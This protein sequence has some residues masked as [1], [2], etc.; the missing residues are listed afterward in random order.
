VAKPT[1]A[2][3][4]AVFVALSHEARRQVL[5]LLAQR[6]GHLPSG[7]LAARFSHSWPTTTR[8]LNV[9]AEAGLVEVHREGRTSV[10]RLRRERLTA[11]IGWWLGHFKPVTAE[12]TWPPTGPRT[13][14]ELAKRRTRKG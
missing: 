10:Y 14:E 12:K 6:G 13:T 9:L 5:L 7:Y 8:H 4:D 3:V 2:E 1:L 11:V